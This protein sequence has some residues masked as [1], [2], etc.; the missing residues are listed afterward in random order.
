[1]T[2]RIR[3]LFTFPMDD[4]LR[5]GLRKVRERDGVSD[6]E[7]IRRGIELWLAKKGVKVK[8]DRKRA[9]TRKRS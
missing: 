4:H 2:P 5:D 3:K 7:Q 6:A 8:W 9:G 1:M